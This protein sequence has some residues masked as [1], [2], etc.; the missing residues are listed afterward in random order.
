[1]DV[2][3]L[4]AAVVPN[5]VERGRSDGALTH[6]LRNEVKIVT[7]RSSDFRIGDRA[8]R[9]VAQ[10]ERQLKDTRLGER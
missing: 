8:R 10:L 1:M 2:I 5:D 9:R 6:R 3:G 7:L 4:E